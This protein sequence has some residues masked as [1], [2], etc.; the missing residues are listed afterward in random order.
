MSVP[1]GN[2]A[3]LEVLK[4]LAARSSELDLLKVAPSE[5]NV[6]EAMGAVSQELRHSDFLAFL[7]DPRANH[8]LG[9]RF[10]KG[11]LKRV[12]QSAHGDAHADN[13]SV[14]SVVDS[15]LFDRIDMGGARVFRERDRIDILLVDQNNR[16]AVVIENKISSGSIRINL[17][18]TAGSPRNASP[19]T[20]SCVSS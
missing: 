16:L 11:W 20:L 1:D 14:A 12:V 10:S 17:P 6:F 9:D 4:V 8:R 5:F 3:E 15:G 7:L 13:A 2:R 18:G 19:A